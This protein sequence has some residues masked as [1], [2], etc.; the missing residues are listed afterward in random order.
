MPLKNVCQECI[1]HSGG[2]C[3]NVNF[4][5]HKSE[6]SPFLEYISTKGLPL[7]HKFEKF[8]ENSDLF[9]YNSSDNPC[10]FLDENHRCQIYDH[11][12]LICRV[13]PVLWTNPDNFFIDMSCPLTNII[14]LRNIANWIDDPRNKEQIELMK[15]LDFKSRQKRYLPIS[16][17]KD[18]FPALEITSDTDVGI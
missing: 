7:G 6:A 13:F 8:G 9:L 4:C 3:T 10:I 18:H 2:C 1:K 14:P 11:R 17:L 15:K 5:I 16:G 12:P